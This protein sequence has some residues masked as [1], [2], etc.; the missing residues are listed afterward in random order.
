MISLQW[1][2][3]HRQFQAQKYDFVVT[4]V[5]TDFEAHVREQTWRTLAVFFI[6]YTWFT[7]I[8]VWFSYANCFNI[9]WVYSVDGRW[10]YVI[11]CTNI[12]CQSLPIQLHDHHSADSVAVSNESVSVEGIHHS[13][14]RCMGHT[15]DYIEVAQRKHPIICIFLPR[16]AM[17]ARSWGS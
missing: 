17:L 9:S 12:N 14:S 11:D 2:R 8:V 13:V 4:T 7:H 3:T 6:V 1:L 5:T 16:E 10:H 15:F